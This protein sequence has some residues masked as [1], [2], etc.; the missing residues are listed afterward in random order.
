MGS[1]F[2]IQALPKIGLTSDV[3]LCFVQELSKLWINHD[4]HKSSLS[5]YELTVD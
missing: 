5:S 2:Q 3:E 4:Q 1:G